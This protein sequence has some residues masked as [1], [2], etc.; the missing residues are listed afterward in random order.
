M[1]N[2]HRLGSLL[3]T[4]TVLGCA[5][6]REPSAER[7]GADAASAVL[8]AGGARAD[9]ALSGTDTGSEAGQGSAVPDA[10]ADGA[11]PDAG[12]TPACEAAQRAHHDYY[13]RHDLSC[14]TDDQCATVRQCTGGWVSSAPAGLAGEVRALEDAEALAC[15]RQSGFDGPLYR[16]ICKTGRC[17]T[18]ETSSWCGTLPSTSCQLQLEIVKVP[19]LDGSPSGELRVLGINRSGQPLT[20]RVPAQCTGQWRITGWPERSQPLPAGCA[21]GLCAAGETRQL[22]FAPGE[23]HEL[24]RVTI[25]RA[26]SGCAPAPAGSYHVSL[27]P[28]VLAGITVCAPSAW[29]FYLPE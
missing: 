8:E 4:L 28:P 12:P 22:S 20:V 17:V 5:D 25:P 16:A 7:A 13:A 15:G 9:A 3:F 23:E 1:R 19:F 2:G 10:G 24:A 18:A 11:V 26:G 21:A 14:T 29:F 27:E 6:E